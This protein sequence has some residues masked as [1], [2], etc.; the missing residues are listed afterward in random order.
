MNSGAAE[1]LDS[2]KTLAAVTIASSLTW[3]AL[4]KGPFFPK[5]LVL[6]FCSRAVKNILSSSEVLA[7]V[8]TK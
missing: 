6:G 1:N 2:K 3:K 7:Y 4:W 5:F 8:D